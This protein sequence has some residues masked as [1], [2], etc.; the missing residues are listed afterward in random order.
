MNEQPQLIA[1]IRE[2]ITNTSFF[3]TTVNEHKLVACFGTETYGELTKYMFKKY[4]A[5]VAI[6]VDLKSKTVSLSKKDG[7]NFKLDVFIK[8]FCNGTCTNNTARGTIT[9]KFMVFTKKFTTC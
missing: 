4:G 5:D 8:T 6:L 9:E 1:Y 7:C 2:K 3:S